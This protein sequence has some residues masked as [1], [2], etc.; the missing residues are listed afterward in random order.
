MGVSYS[1]SLAVGVE[2]PL[3]FFYDKKEVV[4]TNCPHS[5]SSKFCPE[6][7]KPGPYVGTQETIRAEALTLLDLEDEDDFH[8]SINN[9]VVVGSNPSLRLRQ[10]WDN[11]GNQLVLASTF[12]KYIDLDRCDFHTKV[13]APTIPDPKDID[14]QLTELEIPFVPDSFKLHVVI[15]GK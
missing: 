1:M 5:H 10:Y 15:E 7:G 4:R 14:R 8:D 9:G 6:C 12:H 3:D 2:I 13:A 11:C